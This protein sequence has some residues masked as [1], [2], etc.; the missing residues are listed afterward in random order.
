MSLVNIAQMI[1]KEKQMGTPQTYLGSIDNRQHEESLVF[2][3]CLTKPA[4]ELSHEKVKHWK[5]DSEDKNDSVVRKHDD[6][7]SEDLE[8][9]LDIHPNENESA[10]ESDDTDFFDSEDEYWSN[11]GNKNIDDNPTICPYCFSYHLPRSVNETKGCK[12]ISLK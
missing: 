8:E 2:H 3:N 9:D 10:E 1:E 4:I 5:T 11:L 6:I 7:S 12:F